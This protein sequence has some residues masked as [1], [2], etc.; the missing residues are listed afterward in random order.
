MNTNCFQLPLYTSD[1]KNMQMYGKDKKVNLHDFLIDKPDDQFCFRVEAKCMQASGIHP[2]DILIVDS[3][4]TP[5]NGTIVIC[6]YENTIAVR[7]YF[8]DGNIIKLMSGDDD[9]KPINLSGD[10]FI[11][12]WGVVVNVIHS[13]KPEKDNQSSKE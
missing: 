5:Q 7:R 12:I 11:E 8:K 6:S 10:D 4:V 2:G 9:F 13:L 3:S 1:S